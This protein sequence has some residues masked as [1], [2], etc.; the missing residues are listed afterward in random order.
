MKVLR[1]NPVFLVLTILALGCMFAAPG[2]T[3]EEGS[4]E[5]YLEEGMVV[6]YLADEKI[7]IKV[8]GENEGE[9]TSVDFSITEDT[10]TYGEITV[11]VKVEVEYKEKGVAL[12]IGTVEEES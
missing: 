5:T 1:L 10:E 2:I 3:A 11:G 8:H 6:E 9:V 7:T 4:D 12:F